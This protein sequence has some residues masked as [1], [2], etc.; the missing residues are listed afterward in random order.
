MP[1][2]PRLKR[3]HIWRNNQFET[4]FAQVTERCAVDLTVPTTAPSPGP[5][6]DWSAVPPALDPRNETCALH[7]PGRA[8]R[9]RAQLASLVSHALGVLRAGDVCVDFGA[10]SGHL[11]LL[12][13]YLR[14]DCRVILVE[15]KE[16]SVLQAR[17]RIATVALDNCEVPWL[18]HPRSG[19][20]PAT[21]RRPP[22]DPS[23]FPTNRE[24]DARPYK[25]NPSALHGK[26]PQP[27]GPPTPRRSV[28]GTAR[29][30]VMIH[31]P[32]VAG[33][34]QSSESGSDCM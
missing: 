20:R 14:P 27:Q 13:A 28:I 22:L 3:K 4:L 2:G 6:V 10:G 19:C 25:T 16:Y 33:T 5:P 12:L 18:Q 9:K 34:P 26:C 11:G 32:L 21:H 30:C 31:T 17:A 23:H 1:Q 8:D 15:R 24:R 29:P 7:K